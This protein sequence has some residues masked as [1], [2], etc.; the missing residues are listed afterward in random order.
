M[1][2]ATFAFAPL[3]VAALPTLAGCGDRAPVWDAA[4]GSLVASA[5]SDAAVLVDAPGERVLMLPVESDLTLAPVSVPI[6]RGY[7]SSA[8]T[9]DG[10]APGNSGRVVLSDIEFAYPTRRVIHSSSDGAP[11][12]EALRTEGDSAAS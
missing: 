1:R 10:K 6:G 11:V 12:T 5:L 2:L 9:A 3:L 8:T 7:A 4:P